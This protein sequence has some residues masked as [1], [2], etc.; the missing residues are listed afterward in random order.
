[1]RVLLLSS[2]TETINMPVLPLG[3]ASVASATQAA[4]HE[5]RVV[6]LLGQEDARTVLREDIQGFDPEVIGISVRNIDDQ[7]MEPSTFL[8][9]QVR[10]V[11]S[12]CRSLSDAKIVLGGAGY[13]IFPQSALTYLGAD[14]G[15]QGEGE[16]VFVL[17]L[18]RLSRKA[19]LSKIPGLYLE[20]KGLQGKVKF[21]RD[22]DEL[23]LPLP[24]QDHWAFSIKKDSE[25]WLPF[26]TRRG[27]PMECNY[28]STA[29]IE[30]RLIR[31]R[32]PDRVVEA[33][34]RYKEAGIKKFFFVDNTFNLPPSY[35]KALCESLVQADLGILWRC[36][37][38]PNRVD[39]ELV[40]LMAKAGCDEVSLGS[41]SGSPDI[42]RIM[43]KKFLPKD[44]RRISE[45]F[46]KNGIRQMG[47]LLLGGPGETRETVEE[48]VAFAESLELET[49]KVNTGIRIYP[50]TDLARNAVEDGMI[51]PDDDLLFPRHYM[52]KG[53]EDWLKHRV[54]RLVSERPNWVS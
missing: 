29:A 40:E 18:E 27:C 23:P 25:I 51:A 39:N 48:S 14:M 9:S 46:K 36:I 32:S 20:K 35:A 10:G 11:V 24:D 42:L 41:E 49:M 43:N 15:I 31:K 37:I 45:R 47:F 6:D 38:Y 7:R 4:G 13:S 53:I 5:V 12:D 3:L 21:I 19:D 50:H 30:G 2:N 8:L 34:S 52:V 28:C 22:L 17:L 44:V 26:Q 33:L 54:N 1:M 16:K